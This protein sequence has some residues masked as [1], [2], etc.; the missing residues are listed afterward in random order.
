MP[1]ALRPC[2]LRSQ[3]CPPHGF[4]EELDQFEQALWDGEKLCTVELHSLRGD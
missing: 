3:A 1:P 4:N 2:A